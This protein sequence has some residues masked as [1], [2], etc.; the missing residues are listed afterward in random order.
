MGVIDTEAKFREARFFLDRMRALDEPGPG[1]HERFIEYTGYFFSAFL[2]AARSI[3]QH[4]ATDQAFKVWY[5]QTW[6]PSL[7]PDDRAF[8]DMMKNERDYEIHVAKPSQKQSRTVERNFGPGQHPTRMGT[9]SSTTDEFWG[10]PA[11]PL[12]IP[13]DYLFI[14]STSGS[15]DLRVEAAAERYLDLNNKMVQAW[16]PSPCE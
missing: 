4:L 5:D 6:L 11:L 16:L 3:F 1:N 8:Q 10:P 12:S 13:F 15:I 7:G 9:I 14:R 2:S